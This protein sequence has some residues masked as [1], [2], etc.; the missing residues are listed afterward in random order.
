MK[1]LYHLLSLT[2]SFI[3]LS[4]VI[5][6]C[7]IV[8]D[9]EYDDIEI[10]TKDILACFNAE[11]KAWLNLEIP[12]GYSNGATRS[13]FNDGTEY[14]VHDMTIILFH[15]SEEVD[16]RVAS[17][18]TFTWTE[19]M[20]PADQ[21]TKTL[22][23]SSDNIEKGD[24]VYLLAILNY[25][26]SLTSGTLFSE[27]KNS[28]TP[29]TTSY[30]NTDYY[31]MT[32]AP[33][34]TSNDGTGTVQTL[35][36]LNP[37]YFFATEEDALRNPA[38]HIY[39]ERA[40][41]KVTVE[42]DDN[43]PTITNDPYT[44]YYVKGNPNL[45]FTDQH[46]ADYSIYNYHTQGYLVR[47]F[48][49]NWLTLHRASTTDYRFIET[50][51]LPYASPSRYRTYWAKDVNY[52]DDDEE[53]TN[54]GAKGWKKIKTNASG[55]TGECDYCA[56]NTMDLAHMDIKNSTLV[57]VQLNL[58][59]YT[60]FYTTSVTGSDIIYQLPENPQEEEGTSA[61]ESFAR[62]NAAPESDTHYYVSSARTIDE[63]LREWLMQTNSAARNWVNTY[64]A[65]DAN[66]IIIRL[67]DGQASNPRVSGPKDG[68][69]A[70][71]HCTQNARTSGTGVSTFAALNLDT[72]F[73]NNITVNFYDDGYCYYLVPIMHF[74]DTQAPWQSEP[75]MAGSSAAYAYGN[76][77]NDYLG[78]YGVLRNNC[79]NIS[80]TG[81]SHVGGCNVTQLFNKMK[82]QADDTV[83]QLL[84]A[85]L[86]INS[87]E[88]HNES[89]Q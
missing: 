53:I 34:A 83:E 4:V 73:A 7:N 30:N 72:Y 48:E 14:A 54:N 68:G 6:A 82:D 55:S 3:L 28:L 63:Y 17:T 81:V 78:R 50:N 21:V 20:D 42:L 26:P 80:I 46:L 87:W 51:A 25:T 41:A 76:N 66:R 89:L 39:V 13:S 19:W 85:T 12:F 16:A 5:S 31:V 67:D 77:N 35:I 11:G 60:S 61:H 56:E 33:L 59:N 1:K 8:V 29:I 47:H 22:Q 45:V 27:V 43:I 86:V 64:A 38:A 10:P 52:D 15:G 57:L 58:N 65:G 75:T 74:G 84:N 18:Y 62:R 79:Y 69:Q 32:N 49:N 23:V 37:N 88:A 24:N 9:G 70:V 44:D 36:K 71:V 2:A 40:A